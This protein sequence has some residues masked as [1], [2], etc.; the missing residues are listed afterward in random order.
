MSRPFYGDSSFS[1]T[2][3][4]YS[5]A[6]ACL[7]FWAW[8]KGTK[9]SNLFVSVLS[10]ILMLFFSEVILRYVVK[11]PVTYSE[12]QFGTYQTLFT[13]F[14]N[15]TLTDEESEYF[16][17]FSKNYKLTNQTE[18]FTFP[19][20]LTNNQGLRG[21]MPKPNKYN[22]LT[23][24][25]S[26]TESFGAGSDSTYPLLLNN[27]LNNHDSTFQVTNGGISG[28][29]PFYAFKIL[30]KLQPKYNFKAVIF[31]VN[32]SDLYDYVIHGGNSR[33]LSNGRDI[34]KKQPW[35]E[36][37]YATSFVFR[38][39]IHSFGYQYTLITE[40][41]EKKAKLEAIH[42]IRDLFKNQIIPW[43]KREGISLYLVLQPMASEIIYEKE[44]FSELNKQL[45]TLD[46]PFI[47][48]RDS[49]AKVSS[50]QSYYWPKDGHFKP[51]GYY[52]V[53][54]VIYNT[55]FQNQ[56]ATYSSKE[57]KMNL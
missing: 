12:K 52:L 4:Y 48:L 24:G 19:S 47:S 16:Y 54:R 18:E 25:D 42:S 33:F 41:E 3:A 56:K 35:W 8:K 50:I 28:S 30:T 51:K 49:L 31:M 21:E 22:I 14:V 1:V 43:T 5:F 32:T 26:F 46:V 37:I 15:P 29:D 57:G 6:L 7:L 2:C 20:E 23:L 39:L 45:K 53:S 36:P 9:P 38:L 44:E 27:L 55:F 40:E 34:G 13:P 10:T 17:T 11:Y